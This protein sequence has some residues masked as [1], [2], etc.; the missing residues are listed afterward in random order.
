SRAPSTTRSPLQETSTPSNL[1]SPRLHVPVRQVARTKRATPCECEPSGEH[2]GRR[3]G[4]QEG[5]RRQRSPS[6]VRAVGTNRV[7]AERGGF[8]PP[9]PV[10]V[11]LISNQVPSTARSSLRRALCPADRPPVNPQR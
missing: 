10:R 7:T 5:E 1:D 6:S 2:R 3:W 4:S 9:V 8:E 11:R